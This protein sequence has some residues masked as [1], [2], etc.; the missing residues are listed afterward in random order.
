MNAAALLLCGLAVTFISCSEDDTKTNPEDQQQQQGGGDASQG[1]EGNSSE[2]NQPIVPPETVTDVVTFE[3]EYF[4]SLIDSEQYGGPL[5]YAGEDDEDFDYVWKDATTT[6]GSSLTKAWGGF[7]GFSEGGIAI[8]NYLDADLENHV[9][10]M[11]QLA[12][13]KSNGSDNFAIV[14]CD[15]SLTLDVPKTVHAMDVMTTTYCLGYI[16]Y[17]YHGS[18]QLTE[19]GSFLTLIATGYAGEEETGVVKFD[20]ARD[21]KFVE[22]WT[23]VDFSSLGEVDRIEFTMEGSD[24]SPWGL[25][26]PAYFAID[27]VVISK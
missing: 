1:D 19:E 23:T 6:L 4:S 10:F 15:A 25:N 24:S 21:G 5:L 9:S 17:G 20:L 11:Y 2:D 26:S 13:P 8:S 22:D 14:F 7:Y 18:G 27:N 16:K 3:G 12:V